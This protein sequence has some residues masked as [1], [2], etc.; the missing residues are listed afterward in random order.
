MSSAFGNI[1]KDKLIEITE[2][3]LDQDEMWI[4]RVLLI[5]TIAKFK[6]QTQNHSNQI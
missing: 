4:P 5:N 3:F 2:E 6:L 1:W